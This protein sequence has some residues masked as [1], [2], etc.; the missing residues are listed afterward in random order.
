MCGPY[1]DGVETCVGLSASAGTSG[2]IRLGSCGIFVSSISTNCGERAISLPY[3]L[4]GDLHFL[5][6]PYMEFPYLLI[7][8]HRPILGITILL[9][10]NWHPLLGFL[11]LQ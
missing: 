8:F 3:P 1:V 4:L 6:D 7:I 5:P 10:M 11:H 2:G 9:H